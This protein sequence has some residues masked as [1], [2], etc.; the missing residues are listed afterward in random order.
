M[1]APILVLFRGQVSYLVNA[2]TLNTIHEAQVPSKY[3]YI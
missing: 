2:S 1:Q 3:D